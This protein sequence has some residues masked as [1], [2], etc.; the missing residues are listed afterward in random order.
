MSLDD[1]KAS[2]A[3]LNPD[4]RRELIQFMQA[5]DSSTSSPPPSAAPTASNPQAGS[6]WTTPVIVI[7]TLVIVAAVIGWGIGTWNKQ[8]RIQERALDIKEKAIAEEQEARRPRSPTNMEFLRSNLGRDVTIRGVPQGFEVGMLFFHRNP[9]QGLRVEIFEPHVVLYQST[10]LEEWVKNGT[11]LEVFGT[12]ITDPQS[13]G[14][15][16]DVKKQ[17]QIKVVD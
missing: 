5:M 12:L 6:K 4:Q 16:I 2:L 1:W 10:Q 8:Q 11:E 13:G 7:I 15:M 9:D 17:N 3:Q 14:P